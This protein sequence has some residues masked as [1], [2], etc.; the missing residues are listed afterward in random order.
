MNY[1]SDLANLSV[2]SAGSETSHAVDEHEGN[3]YR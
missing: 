2:R 3:R 1:S